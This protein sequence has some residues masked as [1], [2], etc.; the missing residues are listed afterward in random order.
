MDFPVNLNR[1]D[2]VISFNVLL[3]GVELA[4]Q[5]LKIDARE[6]LQKSGNAQSILKVERLW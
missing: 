4:G 6:S 1:V 5:H 3:S 2:F